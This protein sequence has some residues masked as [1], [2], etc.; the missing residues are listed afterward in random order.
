[1]QV[2][3]LILHPFAALS[4]STLC[5]GSRSRKARAYE[6]LEVHYLVDEFKRSR[7]SLISWNK[8]TRSAQH[9]REAFMAAELSWRR[10]RLSRVVY[11][12]W[13]RSNQ[14]KQ[15]ARSPRSRALWRS[16]LGAPCVLFFAQVNRSHRAVAIS[17]SETRRLAS[18]FSVWRERTERCGS[19]RCQ[20]H[21]AIWFWKFWREAIA[22]KRYS[23]IVCNQSSVFHELRF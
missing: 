17:H 12:L 1:M 11:L 7:H 22:V 16:G 14:G 3:N 21:A 4:H 10:S 20:V 8:C 18:Y 5:R 6:S 2:C 15:L 13:S 23:V 19:G 9:R